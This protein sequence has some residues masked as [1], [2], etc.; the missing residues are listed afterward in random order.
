MVDSVRD[1]LA[2]AF[3]LHQSG[4]LGAAVRPYQAILARDRIQADA[5]H[6]LGLVPCQQGRWQE[7]MHRVGKAVARRPGAAAFRTDLAE[8]YRMPGPFD[9]AVGSSRPALRPWRDDPEVTIKFA[10][11]LQGL[12]RHEGTAMQDRAALA[13]RP[14]DDPAGINLGNAQMALGPFF[15][16]RR[17]YSEAPRLKPDLA[18]KHTGLGLTLQEGR[19]PLP[20]RREQ[21]VRLLPDD[22]LAQLPPGERLRR[23][24]EPRF[25]MGHGRTI[26]SA[27]IHEVDDL[28]GMVRRRVAPCVRGWEPACL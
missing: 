21:P 9:R 7:A 28:E 16:G 15:E 27:S 20:A 3:R 25:P 12:G 2:G 26:L 10:L 1:D 13:P 22:Q 19:H 5:A 23:I 6:L 11:A 18:H 17:A 8:A 24:R 4:V 14:D